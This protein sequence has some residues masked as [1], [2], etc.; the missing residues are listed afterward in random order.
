MHEFVRAALPWVIMG[1]CIA[2]FSANKSKKKKT[3]HTKAEGDSDY[4]SL[5]MSLGMCAGVALSSIFSWNLGLGISL[6]MLIGMC[7]G[8]CIK[9]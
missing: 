7:I 5:Y 6:G 8:F 4:L 3:S 1:L 2:I 9:K